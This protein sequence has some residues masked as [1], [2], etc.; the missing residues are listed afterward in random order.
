M[1]GLGVVVALAAVAAGGTAGV[2]AL[3]NDGAGPVVAGQ[4][5]SAASTTLHTP[6]PPVATGA[7]TAANAIGI[8]PSL[9]HFSVPG[10]VTDS[11][12]TTWVSVEGLESVEFRKS[13]S[14]A[15]VSIAQTETALD[16]LRDWHTSSN[17]DPYIPGTPTV[18]PPLPAPDVSHA[19]TVA[20]RPGTMYSW[21]HPPES[22]GTAAYLRW[23]PAPGVWAQVFGS[24]ARPADS[25][26]IVKVAAAL[27]L[28]TV[29]RCT[30]PFQLKV[31]VGARL[32]SCH[33][34]LSDDDATGFLS[35]V[36]TVGTGTGALR[37]ESSPAGT[38]LKTPPTTTVAGHP[39]WQDDFHGTRLM[40]P[41][42]G[43]LGL[44]ITGS[45]EY[46]GLPTV[47]GVAEGVRVAA[48]PD[49]PSTWPTQTVK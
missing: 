8:D 45:G 26:N 3:R 17:G 16:E 35:S 43:K 19:V 39:A 37:I 29:Y 40:I 6:L 14:G 20:G 44:N 49:N 4:T 41:T 22:A 25:Q 42:F 33:L 11:E 1:R 10:L 21:S 38:V 32:Q 18:S 27:R 2:R 5:P 12:V 34:T 13:G 36:L 15:E 7:S 9:I 46:A 47:K 48:D 31:P 23:Q 30:A 28:G 24:V